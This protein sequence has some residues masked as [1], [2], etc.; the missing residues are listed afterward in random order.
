MEDLSTP[1]VD[2]E[3]FLQVVGKLMRTITTM[4]AHTGA[5]Q[6]VC[7]QMEEFP[8]DLYMQYRQQILHDMEPAL[9]RLEKSDAESF[10]ELL[11]AVE[12]PSRSV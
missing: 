5:M 2:Y 9:Q 8:F 3:T 4:A 6:K 11:K 12:D 10:L 1:A 7:S